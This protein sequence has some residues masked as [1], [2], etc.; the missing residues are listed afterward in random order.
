MEN[1]ATAPIANMLHKR[2]AW[3]RPLPDEVACL[4]CGGF[5]LDH[6][7]IGERQT[8]A[9]EIGDL[10]YDRTLRLTL[11]DQRCKCL[12]RAQAKVDKLVADANLPKGPRGP[13]TFETWDGNRTNS[14]IYDATYA[15]ISR[16]MPEHILV[17]VGDNGCGKSHLLEAAGRYWL[18]QGRPVRYEVVADMLEAF[19]HTFQGAE[20]APDVYAWLAWYRSRDLL[21]LD[22]LG[23]E[24]GTDWTIEKVFQIIDERLRDSRLTII[25]TNNTEAEMRANAGP[26]LTSRLYQ[27]NRDLEEV[28]CVTT[29]APSW[30]TRGRS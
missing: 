2:P 14:D 30:R 7:A 10:E 20:N 5:F 8:Q 27:T 15:F 29:E 17:L 23:V 11:Q 21:L 24:K 12:E 19:R 1:W 13:R 26:R 9:A 4:V 16:N 28:R 6:P 3:A 25:A 22:D 18:A